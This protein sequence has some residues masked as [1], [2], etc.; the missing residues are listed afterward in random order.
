MSLKNRINDIFS[1]YSINL[2]VEEEIKDEIK[3]EV[4][5]EEEVA[6]A[7]KT[8]VNGT[9][10]YTDAEDF[11]V[12]AAVFIV[13]DEGER[14]PLPDGEYEYEGGGKTLIVEGVIAE[15]L[16]E[17]EVE[18]EEEKEKE[19]VVVEMAKT[20]THKQVKAMVAKAVRSAKEEFS[21]ATS[22]KDLEIKAMKQKLSS[23]SADKGLRKSAK[24][25]PQR[26]DL[27]KLSRKERVAAI[28]ELYS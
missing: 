19:E 25:A 24:P 8:L 7:E 9:V 3:E 14:M 22:R 20:F 17:H 12:G 26:R 11:N 28:H 16:D 4:K 27:S 15:A 6:L 13:N 18:E 21:K 1:S 2:Q 10:I 5:E 23:V